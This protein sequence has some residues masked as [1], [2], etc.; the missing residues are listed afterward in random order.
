MDMK[1][2][3]E[4]VRKSERRGEITGGGEWKWMKEQGA[5]RKEEKGIEQ[6]E[7]MKRREEDRIEI[8]K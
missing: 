7:R 3:R 8:Q 5:K 6:N 2:G 4:C 1:E